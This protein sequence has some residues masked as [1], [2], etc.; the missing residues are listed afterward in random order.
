MCLLSC[1][2]CGDKEDGCFSSMCKKLWYSAVVRSFLKW[3]W[4]LLS[5]RSSPS[6]LHI[7]LPNFSFAVTFILKCE[8]IQILRFIWPWECK[9]SELF[10]R[11]TNIFR[12]FSFST[13]W[14]Q[15]DVQQMWSVRGFCLVFLL[16]WR[17][18]TVSSFTL[19]IYSCLTFTTNF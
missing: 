19:Y 1:K 11:K 15:T 3:A 4:S 18:D 9:Q 14:F 2:C 13:E 17:V 16:A 7:S 10:V 5:T 12:F 6:L 8:P